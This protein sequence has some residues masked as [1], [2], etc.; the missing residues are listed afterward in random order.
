M[1]ELVH[2]KALVHGRVQ[3]IYYRAF[4]SRAAK[5]LSLK[6]YVRNVSNGDVELEAEGEKGLLEELLRRLRTGPDGAVVKKIDIS[7]PEYT[8]KHSSF[9][10]RF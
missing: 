8:G 1:P 5:S 2:F 10:V 9:D 4:A 6:G 7:W 3:G